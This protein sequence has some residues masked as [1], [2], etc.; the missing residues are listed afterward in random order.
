MVLLNNENPE[1]TIV[2]EAPAWNEGNADPD[3][4]TEKQGEL[5][6]VEAR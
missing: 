2:E 5:T 3:D 4:L 6:V 1:P